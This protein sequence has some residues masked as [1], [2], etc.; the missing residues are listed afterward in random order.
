MHLCIR[1]ISDK[2]TRYNYTYIPDTN[3]V[4]LFICRQPSSR[5]IPSTSS[6]IAGYACN[7]PYKL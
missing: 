3:I 1:Y 2:Y 6:H 4:T 5:K 7:F